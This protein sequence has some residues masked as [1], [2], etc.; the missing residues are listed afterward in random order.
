MAVCAD[1]LAATLRDVTVRY[2]AHTVLDR[3]TVDLPCHGVTALVGP[4]GAGKSTLLAVLL[5]QAPYQGTVTFTTHLKAGRTRP[6]FGLVPQALNFDATAPVSVLDFLCLGDGPRPFWLGRDRRV[7]EQAWAALR[8][9]QAETLAHKPLGKLSGGEL[10][11]VMVAAALRRD[12]DILL[13]D[14]PAAGLDVQGENLFCE[15]LDR[16]AAERL[17]TVLWVSHD[18]SAVTRHADHVIAL[19]Q[20]VLLEGKPP[21]VLT[22]TAVTALYGLM[23]IG[24]EPAHCETCDQPAPHLHL[25]RKA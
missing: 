21:E 4:N 19:R 9:T 5:G 15:L 8:F 18:L 25:E 2:G 13:L 23:A 3:V 10:K 24:S 6:L 7:A 22:A 14:E 11:C 1:H 12:P 16:L 17:I 20:R